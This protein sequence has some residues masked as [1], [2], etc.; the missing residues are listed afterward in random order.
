MPYLSKRALQGLE[1]YKYKPAGYTKLD[2][3]HTPFWNC[4]SLEV[5][6]W[7]SSWAMR[8]RQDFARWRRTPNI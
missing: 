7:G 4:E 2:E 8:F 5:E 6:G 1:A 3:I